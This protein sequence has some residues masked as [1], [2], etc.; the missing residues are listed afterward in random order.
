MDKFPRTQYIAFLHEVQTMM[1]K[2]KNMNLMCPKIG[3]IPFPC[4]TTSN[5][6]VRMRK[7]IS[8]STLVFPRKRGLER[9]LTNL[10]NAKKITEQMEAT[11]SKSGPLDLPSNKCFELPRFEKKKKGSTFSIP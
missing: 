2:F 7:R 11:Y 10:I 6:S 3:L 4:E 9:T 1:V 5:E 8:N